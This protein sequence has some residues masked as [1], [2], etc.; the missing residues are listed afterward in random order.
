MFQFR[1]THL[2]VCCLFFFLQLR[3]F[4]K[5]ANLV[6]ANSVFLSFLSNQCW[7]WT[8]RANSVFLSFLS[9]PCWVST[10]RLRASVV[11]TVVC[12]PCYTLQWPGS[13]L[14]WCTRKK[15]TKLLVGSQ[16]TTPTGSSYYKRTL[17]D[18]LHL[19]VQ[20]TLRTLWLAEEPVH[21]TG[22]WLH[23]QTSHLL[24]GANMQA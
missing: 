14:P 18:R 5:L 2:V 3:E 9:N 4:W 10:A 17:W 22:K 11:Q 19:P 12:W 23:V 15:R 16:A 6:W 8:A 1:L 24:E 20:T 21:D 13:I 7:V